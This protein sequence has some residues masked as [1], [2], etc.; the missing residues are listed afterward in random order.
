MT[1]CTYIFI[2]EAGNL[3]FSAGGSRYFVLAG[4]S[5]KRPFQW[6][7]SL[8]DYKYDCIEYGLD[9]EYFHC[10]DDNKHVRGRVFDIIDDH[11]DAMCIDYLVV[12]KSKTAPA[13]RDD[14]RFYPEMLGCL[15]KF[16]LPEEFS[17]D[18]DEIIVITDTIPVNKK[19]KAIEKGI[20]LALAKM[21]PSAMKYR[22]LHHDS[23]SHYGLQ[24]ADYCCWA[25]YRKLQTGE[26]SW[27][28]HI[29]PAVR[30][31]FDIFEEE[32]RDF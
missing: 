26:T 21:L 31:G 10:T 8:D 15:L 2:D 30:S 17:I 29:R 32:T 9:N 6:F 5:M 14:K 7:Q 16:M 13:L 27:F 3:D 20:R 25:V 12:E 24:A 18:A 19:R 23:R 22:M 11:L 1:H 4:V 28:D